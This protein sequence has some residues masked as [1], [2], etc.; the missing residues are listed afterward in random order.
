MAVRYQ[1]T[2][3]SGP[4]PGTVFTLEKP[5]L[6]LG[7]ELTGDIVIND[8]EVS[9]KHARFSFQGGGY[10]IEDL[11]STNGTI[12][13]GQ[14]LTVPLALRGGEVITIGEHVSLVYE[15]IPIDPDATVATFRATGTQP[16]KSPVAGSPAQPSPPVSVPETT[17][18]SYAGQVPASPVEEVL[19]IHRRIPVWL[20]ILLAAILVI[21]CACAGTLWY[22]DANRLWCTVMPFLAGCP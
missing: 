10:L 7:R 12:V 2:I 4:T 19:P 15:V 9:R 8:A 6:F 21:I 22:I 17:P 1:L 20:V 14:R 13:S 16:L 18:P 5:E 3:H 11:G